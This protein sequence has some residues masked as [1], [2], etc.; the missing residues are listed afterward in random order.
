MANGPP[1]RKCCSAQTL[2][3]ALVGDRRDHAGLP[4]VP[5]DGRDFGERAQPR[6]R[7]VGGDDQPRPQPPAVG[8]FEL[9]DVA[10]GRE[11]GHGG[12]DRLEAERGGRAA[13][14]AGDVVVERHMG[15]RFVV[16][17]AEAQLLDPHCVA[18]AAVIDRHAADR[19]GERLER[20]PGADLL[21]QAA[22]PFGE[23]HRA[24][25]SVAGE[26]ARIDERDGDPR[27]PEPA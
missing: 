20:R 21:D 24:Q 7:A 5:A 2:V 10:S 8:E 17:A 3:V 15:E 6:A 25:P 23:R 14:R 13:K 18:H 22:R 11:R 16:L 26:R 1:G 4:G 12:D 19:L 9:G 27:A